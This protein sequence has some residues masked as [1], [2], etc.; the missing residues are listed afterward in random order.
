LNTYTIL[1]IGDGLVSQ[2]PALMISAATSFIVTRA[3]SDDNISTELIKQLVNN[4]RLLYVTAGISVVLSL[5]LGFVPFIVIAIILI[6]IASIQ[7]RQKIE[8]DKQEELEVEEEEVEEIRR[9]ENVVS[10]LAG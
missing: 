7:R 6:V 8:G 9:P 3:V 1:T 2:L 4:Y 10:L 5:F